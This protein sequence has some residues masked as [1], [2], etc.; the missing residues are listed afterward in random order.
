MKDRQGGDVVYFALNVASLEVKI[1]TTHSI[2]RRMSAL[3]S[4]ISMFHLIATIPGDRS[5][6]ARV[7][8]E[9]AP[10]HLSRECFKWTPELHE[11]IVRLLS[12]SAA[13]ISDAPQ[14][15]PHHP[16]QTPQAKRLPPR[17]SVKLWL[18]EETVSVVG[19]GLS[20][21]EAF[22]SYDAWSKIEVG[23]LQPARAVVSPAK[24]WREL[25]RFVKAGRSFHGSVYPIAEA[26]HGS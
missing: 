2:V 23:A 14:M 25:N 16:E 10:W 8:A 15:R 5:V 19:A 12:E 13:A 9:F 4:T 22:G 7:H 11:R 26:L 24:F 17:D 21:K 1:G 20:A 18:K 6:E 3:R